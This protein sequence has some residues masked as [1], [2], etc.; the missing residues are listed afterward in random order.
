[1]KPAAEGRR[2]R[3]GKKTIKVTKVSMV[4]PMAAALITPAATRP[5]GGGT[6]EEWPL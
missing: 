2:L 4:C 3:K 1:M 6:C 5:G